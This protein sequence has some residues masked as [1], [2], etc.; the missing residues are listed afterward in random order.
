MPFPNAYRGPSAAEALAALA[1]AFATRVARG[2]G[3]GDR[4]RAGPGRGRLHPGG[5]RVP[6]RPAL[7]LRRARDRPGRA[8]RCSPDSRGPGASSPIEHFGVEPDLI[9]VAKSIAGGLPLSGV[10]GKA[11]IMDAPAAGGVGGTF[12]G[13]PVAQAAAL[14][15]LDVIEDEG[16]VERSAAIGETMRARMESLAEPLAERRRRSRSRFDARDRAR[17]GPADE[18]SGDGAGRPRPGGGA[19][20]AACCCCAPAYTA[21]AS[22]CSCPLVISDGEL[23]EALDLW[24]DA[25][26]ASNYAPPRATLNGRWSGRCSWTATSSRSSS[27]PAAC[28]ASTGRTTGSSTARSR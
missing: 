7:D 17:R 27:A 15:V 2:D 5:R 25:L 1:R 16:L 26:V 3:G 8:T 6:A 24:E 10:L 20:R 12:V 28:R 11:E 4:R 9:T 18:G 19:R 21:T 22:G 13:N 23:A 14:A